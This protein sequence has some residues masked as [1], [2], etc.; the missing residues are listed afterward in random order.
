[1]TQEELSGRSGLSVRCISDLER[2]VSC[3]RVSTIQLLAGVWQLSEEQRMELNALARRRRDWR[4]ALGGALPMSAVLPAATGLAALLLAGCSTGPGGHGAAAALTPPALPAA[5]TA[6]PTG[7]DGMIHLPLS[8][9]QADDQAD[10]QRR[11]VVQALTMR[12]LRDGGYTLDPQAVFGVS[13]VAGQDNATA[14]P[15][16]PWGYLGAEQAATQGF[17][18]VSDP[19][20]PQSQPGQPGQSGQSGQSAQQPMTPA[21]QTAVQD[22]TRKALQTVQPPDTPARRLVSQLFGDSISAAA[23]DS[24]VRSADGR[25]RDCMARA[26]IQATDP[27]ALVAQYQRQRPPAGEQELTAAEADAACTG[28][29]GLAA[30]YF[31]VLAGYQQE[32]IDRHSAELAGQQQAVSA[33]SARIA[34]LLAGG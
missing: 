27:Q 23:G 19:Q 12:C 22:C 9:Y 14:L 11:Q 33:E 15:G 1:M 26:G 29:T 18:G 17:H 13:R 24:R 2:G 8:A 32:Q 34:K 30:T 7:R 16:G 10:N 31:A 28:S 6:P 4:A 20:S 5:P 25:W 3:P 21:E